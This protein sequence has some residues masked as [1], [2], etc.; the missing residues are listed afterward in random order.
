M[1]KRAAL[2]LAVTIPSSLALTGCGPKSV[3]VAPPPPELTTCADEPAAPDLPGQDRQPERDR[4][5]LDYILSLRSAWGD[6]R[7][8]VDGVRA[9]GAALGK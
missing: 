6:C 9:W 4:L 2:L 5:T 7:A 8:K 1:T 3:R